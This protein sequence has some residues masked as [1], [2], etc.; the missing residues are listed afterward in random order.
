MGN[1][2]VVD[3]MMWLAGFIFFGYATAIIDLYRRLGAK[4]D[5][6]VCSVVKSGLEKDILRLDNDYELTIRE[7]RAL[8][9][10]INTI[11]K[12]LSVILYRL[13]NEDKNPFDPDKTIK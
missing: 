6:T 13:D 7:I 10:T 4:Q 9:A 8:T 5:M 2:K 1:D 12:Q 3:I 11:S